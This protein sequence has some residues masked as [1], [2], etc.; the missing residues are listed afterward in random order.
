MVRRVFDGFQKPQNNP[1][2]I[3]ASF[4]PTCFVYLVLYDER[5]LKIEMK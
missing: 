4:L 2:K 3:V 1:T 5:R